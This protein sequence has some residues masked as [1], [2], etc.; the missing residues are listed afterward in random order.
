MYKALRVLAVMLVRICFRFSVSGRENI[1]ASGAVLVSNHASMF[2]PVVLGVAVPRPIHFMGKAELFRNR[3]SNWF[4]RKLH[5]FPVRRGEF[6]RGAIRSA[7]EVLDRGQL[8]GIFPEGTRNRGEDLMPLHSG[9]ALLAS[10]A[11][12]PI[13]PIV[14]VGN[15]KYRIFHRVDVRIGTP[16]MPKQGKKATKEDLARINDQILAQFTVLNRQEFS[17]GARIETRK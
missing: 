14:I 6:D 16:I 15:N 5:A 1:P 3:I 7:L 11:Q 8:L 10:R 4:F 13:I 17:I 12:V 2:D 9:A